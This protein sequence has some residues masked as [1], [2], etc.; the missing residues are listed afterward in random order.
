[1]ADL[2]K[3]LSSK[4][5]TSAALD[6]KKSVKFALEEAPPSSS[7]DERV[8]ELERKLEV[9]N[10]ERQDILQA[11]EKEIEYHRSDDSLIMEE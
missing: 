9:A 1:M 6:R 2:E 10:R 5:S 4:P 3:Q 8:A 7:S 11:A